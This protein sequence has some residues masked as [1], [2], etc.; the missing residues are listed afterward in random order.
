MILP[1]TNLE[2]MK[3]FV[4]EICRRYK[5]MFIVIFCDGASC[6]SQEKLDIPGRLKIVHIPPY[7]PELNPVENFWKSLKL[8]FLEINISK[9]W[10]ICSNI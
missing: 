5:N 10:T 7:S 2:C 8:V 4:E 6:H 3:L 9:L 1:E